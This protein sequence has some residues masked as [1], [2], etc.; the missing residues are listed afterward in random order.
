MKIM[1]LDRHDETPIRTIKL[2]DFSLSQWLWLAILIRLIIPSKN[3]V[4]IYS[5]FSSASVYDKSVV[6]I[7]LVTTHN[8]D[9]IYYV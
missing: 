3:N 4:L 7:H 1:N 2:Q 8:E 6:N 5:K 9:V